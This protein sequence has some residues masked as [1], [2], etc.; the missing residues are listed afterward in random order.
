[1]RKKFLYLF[2]GLLTMTCLCSCDEHE[3]FDP[4]IHSG[5]ILCSDGSIVA[6]NVFDSRTQTPVA[7]VFAEQ[8][9]E[10]PVLAV[11][12]DEIDFIAFADTL[13][14]DQK[15][16]CSL[17]SCDGYLNTVALQTTN[18]QR[19]VLVD[20]VHIDNADNYYKSP[21]GLMAF[22]SHWFSQSDYVPSV[23]ELELLYKALPKV[24]PL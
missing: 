3:P 13:S 1:M 9:A 2:V 7:V 22:R 24:N 4:D 6:D 19:K 12:L 10:H 17:D 21:L 8:T 11:L 18:I 14:F 15:T 20:S 23:M 16:S 5:Y